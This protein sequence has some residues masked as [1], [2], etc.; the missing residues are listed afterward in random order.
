MAGGGF[1]LRAGGMGG[2]YFK[3]QMCEHSMILPAK[4][5]AMSSTMSG[6]SIPAIC[7]GVEFA[8]Q[9]VQRL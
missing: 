5:P 3:R 4:A 8:V 6:G 9:I 7:S 1:I 2:G